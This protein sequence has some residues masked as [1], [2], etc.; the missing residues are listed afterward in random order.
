MAVQAL[1]YVGIEARSP[2]DWAGYGTDF[3]GLQLAERSAGQLVFRMDDRRQRLVV[4]PGERDGARFFGWEVA[5][6]AALTAIAAR[7]DAAGVA[8][9][10]G[11]RALADQR[12]VAGLIS[13][14]DPIGNRIEL[15]H[16]A[17][18]TDAPFIPGRN[19][20]GF[21]TGALG[22]GHAVLTVPQMADVLPFYRDLL[23]FR[24]SDYVTRPFHAY[25]L[26]VNPRHHSLALIETGSAGLHHLMIELFSLDDVGQGYDL[27]LLEEGRVATTLGRHTND[28]MT[29][30]YARTPGGFMMEYGW[31]GRT[32]DPATWQPVEMHS[33]PSLWGHERQW[34]S[35]EMRAEARR[36]RLQAARNGERQPVQVLP[37]NH[38]PISGE[39]AWWDMAVRG[40]GMGGPR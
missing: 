39:C 2:E 18:A 22:M 36:L 13:L 19:I 23:G 14:Q 30:F 11:T 33:G 7:L 9:T 26:H 8:V 28:F 34:S 24:V 31:G 25:F 17:E 12:R 6:A 35:P 21:R 37:G 38:N 10:H 40:H 4:M 5:D 1:G 29:S 16:G 3:L 32:V 27:A 15:V 20:S